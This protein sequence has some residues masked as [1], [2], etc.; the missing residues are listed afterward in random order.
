MAPV[1]H[2][3]VV[4]LFGHANRST[5]GKTIAWTNAA[6]SGVRL[7]PSFSSFRRPPAPVSVSR[8]PGV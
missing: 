6:L 7:T 8:S 2:G 5:S 3:A 1:E 4:F